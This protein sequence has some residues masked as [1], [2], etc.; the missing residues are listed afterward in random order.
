MRRRFGGST[1]E[2]ESL[3]DG[4]GRRRTPGWEDG[5]ALEYLVLRIFQLDGARV[6][7]PYRV[8]IDPEGETVE[9]IDGAVHWGSLSCLIETKDLRA[10]HVNVEPIAKLRNQLLRRPSSTV[11][12]VFSRTG[13]TSAAQYLA[14]FNAPQA[15]LLWDGEEIAFAIDRRKIC[16]YL[17]EKYYVCVESGIP[18][19]DIRMTELPSG[20]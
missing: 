18:Y 15:I 2:P 8:E 11:G 12:L 20:S 19:F 10:D 13:F 4:I 1:G 16:D 3:W 14:R 5:K 6:R 17:I 9:Q 7:W